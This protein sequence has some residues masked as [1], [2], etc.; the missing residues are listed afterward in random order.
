MDDNAK[1]EQELADSDARLGLDKVRLLR[2][3]HRH[4]H[5]TMEIVVA[6]NDY[7]GNLDD[8]EPVRGYLAPL[9]SRSGVDAWRLN[10]DATAGVWIM[11]AGDVEP[12]EGCYVAG[13]AN[14]TDGYFTLLV[15]GPLALYKRE[16]RYELYVLGR[17][18]ELPVSVLLALGLADPENWNAAD[19]LP[20]PPSPSMSFRV[21][22]KDAGLLEDVDDPIL[23]DMCDGFEDTRLA[24]QID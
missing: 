9:G 12:V 21:G 4:G 5:P 6:P 15:M 16:G 11:V 10:P 22:I 17:K 7:A 1:A 23:D 19:P 8:Y 20:E 3:W 24:P 18:R 14:A 13:V 2:W